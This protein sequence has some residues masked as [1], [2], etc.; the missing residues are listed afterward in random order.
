MDLTERIWKFVLVTNY[1]LFVHQFTNQLRIVSG[2][3][4]KEFTNLQNIEISPLDV[5]IR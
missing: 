5:D 3:F 2:G 1:F 4:I